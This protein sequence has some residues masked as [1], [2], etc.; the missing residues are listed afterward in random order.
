MREVIDLVQNAFLYFSMGNRNVNR[1][2]VAIVVRQGT[3]WSMVGCRVKRTFADGWGRYFCLLF[4]LSIKMSRRT[5]IYGWS[6]LCLASY[7]LQNF[8]SIE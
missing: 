1:L 5:A 3:G 6:Q 8:S 4:V 2:M 7:L